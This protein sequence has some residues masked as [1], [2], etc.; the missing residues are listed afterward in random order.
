MKNKKNLNLTEK[1]IF[2]ILNT[3]YSGNVLLC[4]SLYHNIKPEIFDSAI[5]FVKQGVLYV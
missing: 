5:N 2:F 1:Q 4:N 3:V